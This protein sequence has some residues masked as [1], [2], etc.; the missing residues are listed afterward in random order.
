[1][2]PIK[3]KE[4]VLDRRKTRVIRLQAELARDGGFFLAGGTGLGLRLGHRLSNDLDWFTPHHFNAKD[5]ERRLG[6][7]AEKPTKVALQSAHTVRAY[8]GTLETSFITYGQVPASPESVQVAGAEIPLADLE[9]MAAMK[10]AAVHDRGAKRDFI[11]IHAITSHPGWSV[12]RFIEHAVQV[13]PFQPEQVTRALTYFADAD[14]DVMP[15][16]C[17]VSWK[18]V[19]DDLTKGVRAWERKRNS[20][21]A[22]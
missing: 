20:G 17:K 13:L 5:L 2:A 6:A 1:V 15:D 16:G 4:Q 7:L 9:I 22:R 8:Y 19:K 12:G 18:K 3:L 10:A 14:K 11:D 21:L